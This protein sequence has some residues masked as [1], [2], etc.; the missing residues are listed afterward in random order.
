LP[1][2][3][4]SLEISYF[5]HAT[6]DLERVTRTI[7]GRF[8]LSEQPELES[9]EG[10]FGNRIVRV[11]HRVTGAEAVPAFRLLVALIGRDAVKELLAEL[12]LALDDHK[13]LYIRLGKQE[14]MGGI[15][16]LS[17]TDP[18][19]VKVKPR[20]FMM[21]GDVGRFYSALLLQGSD[22]ADDDDEEEKKK[23]QGGVIDA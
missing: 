20:G 18:V 9:L 16:A 12:D 19:R 5:V 6:E 15:A 14:L 2:E 8:G 21:K 17:S 11:N 7:S 4:Q 13:A 3:I 23:Q 1:G 10:H 22:D